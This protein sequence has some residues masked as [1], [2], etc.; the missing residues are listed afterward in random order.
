MKITV[1]NLRVEFKPTI[2]RGWRDEDVQGLKTIFNKLQQQNE[3]QL[4]HFSDNGD[5]AFIFIDASM[6]N[7]LRYIQDYKQ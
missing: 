2:F 7:W 1:C 4:I 3:I 5:E 6:H